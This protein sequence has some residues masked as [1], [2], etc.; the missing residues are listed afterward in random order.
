M[1]GNAAATPTVA[2][3]CKKNLLVIFMPYILPNPQRQLPEK[4]YLI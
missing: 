1:D 4:T 3:F 2:A